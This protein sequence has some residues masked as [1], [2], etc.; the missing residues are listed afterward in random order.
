AVVLGFLTVVVWQQ[1]T[2]A[3][4]VVV[5]ESSA[6]IDAWHTA[7]GLPPAVRERVRADVVRYANIMIKSEW[8]SMRRGA[9]D[10]AAGIVVMDAIDAAGSFL[11]ANMSESNAQVATLQ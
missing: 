9:F 2:E 4:Q 10:E 1:F 3:R 6:D 11:P 8:P 5:S 7:V